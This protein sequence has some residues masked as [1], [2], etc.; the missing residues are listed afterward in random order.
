M[1]RCYDVYY[2]DGEKESF[3][4]D[5]EQEIRSVSSA[6]FSSSLAH[7]LTAF[8]YAVYDEENIKRSMESF[9]FKD[10]VSDYGNDLIGYSLGKKGMS[11]GRTLVLVAIRGSS[12]TTEWLSNFNLFETTIMDGV[13][14]HTGFWDA[15][16]IVFNALESCLNG[17]WENTV[18]VFTGHSRGAAAANI[19]E[20]Y[21]T[22]HQGVGRECVY[23]YNIACPDVAAGSDSEWNPSGECDNIFN[24]AN[25]KDIV[26]LIPGAFGNI[27]FDRGEEG[28]GKF[29]RSYW[30]A[31]NE[32]DIEIDISTHELSVYLAYL[33]KE[34]PL[35]F[36][37]TRDGLNLER[38]DKVLD[39]G[40]RMLKK[41]PVDVVISDESGEEI[42]SLLDGEVRFNDSSVK[43]EQGKSPGPGEEN[44][45]DFL[46][47][48]GQLKPAGMN[49]QFQNEEN[50]PG[51]AG[52]F[53]LTFVASKAE[54][55]P[56]EKAKKKRNGAEGSGKNPAAGKSVRPCY[57]YRKGGN[58][59][60][61]VEE[62]EAQTVRMIFRMYLDGERIAGIQKYLNE[63]DIPSPAGRRT[64]TWGTIEKMLQNEKYLG[65]DAHPGIIT[66]ELF[67]AAEEY[68]K[69]RIGRRGKAGIDSPPDEN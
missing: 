36:Y 9:G 58:G 15:A 8:S 11:D 39:F 1:D 42:A 47:F 12:S 38:T 41:S 43:E 50:H 18:F 31:E 6:E 22:S 54:G 68:R 52:R 33:R 19:L 30:F 65:S 3:P 10:P 5:I 63:Q 27:F 35:D 32:G 4:R 69:N 26:S 17:C 57:G 14:L 62:S 66:N 2:G 51:S 56:S 25:A 49:L 60:L 64:W 21:L 45:S 55:R 29:G 7:L 61:I 40:S 37:E 24:L 16:M 34:Y 53:R 23:G 13:S 48:I 28:W 46:T 44:S 20:K 67:D 59:H